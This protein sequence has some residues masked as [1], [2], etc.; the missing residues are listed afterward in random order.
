M[1]CF[2]LTRPLEKKQRPEPG[3]V[4]RAL[5][6]VE[7]AEKQRGLPPFFCPLCRMCLSM[8][9]GGLIPSCEP[10]PGSLG[11][12]TAPLPPLRACTSEKSFQQHLRSKRHLKNLQR[13]DGGETPVPRRKKKDKKSPESVGKKSLSLGRL[14]KYIQFILVPVFAFFWR[15]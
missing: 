12:R 9:L 3:H 15:G 14:V 2:C 1:S 4:L 6:K 11:L 13:M 8:Q 10:D 5:R 7:F